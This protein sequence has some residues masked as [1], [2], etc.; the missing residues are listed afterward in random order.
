MIL[1]KKKKKK[2]KNLK[3]SNIK[4]FEK[5]KNIKELDDLLLRNY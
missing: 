4:T 1:Q 3:T 2:K 5:P